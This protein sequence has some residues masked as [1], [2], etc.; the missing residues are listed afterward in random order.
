MAFAMTLDPPRLS[1]DPPPSPPPGLENARL[2]RC[3]KEGTGTM[4]ERETGR[5]INEG[6]SVGGE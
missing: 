5:R 2:E 4:E 1:L 6:K 3:F